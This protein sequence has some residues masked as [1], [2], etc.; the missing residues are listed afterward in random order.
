[1]LFIIPSSV[2]AMH[3]SIADGL[4][5]QFYAACVFRLRSPTVGGTPSQC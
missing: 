4:K 3:I 2:A 5:K 1:M